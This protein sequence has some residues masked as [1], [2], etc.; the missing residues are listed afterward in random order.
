MSFHID[1]DECWAS[2]L[3]ANSIKRSSLD[4]D[5]FVPSVSCKS[6]TFNSTSDPILRHR[7]KNM[8]LSNMKFCRTDGIR[9]CTIQ[10]G[11]TADQTPSSEQ[12]RRMTVVQRQLLGTPDGQTLLF[13]YQHL[14]QR[15]RPDRLISESRC[16]TP[17]LPHHAETTCA[18][19]LRL[20]GP[21]HGKGGTV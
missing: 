13:D 21:A 7:R 8:R 10:D 9:N 18:T 15:Q 20:E 11:Y 17:Q 3:S 5:R 14:H 4:P 19:A 12:S 6:S 1:F 16:R 2:I